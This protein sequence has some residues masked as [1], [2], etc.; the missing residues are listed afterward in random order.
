MYLKQTVHR[1]LVE[2]CLKL[3]KCNFLRTWEYISLELNLVT[4][5]TRLHGKGNIIMGHLS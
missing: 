5:P 1:I 2:K 4:M 3:E